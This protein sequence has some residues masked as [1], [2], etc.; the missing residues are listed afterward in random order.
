[1]GKSLS[2][3]VPSPKIKNPSKR[4]KY[5]IHE[6]FTVILGAEIGAGR[7][8][9]LHHARLEISTG[10]NSTSSHDIIAK[11]AFDDYQRERIYHEYD[12]YYHLA[13]SGVQGYI[14]DVYGLFEDLEGGALALLMSYE[15]KTLREHSPS[16]TSVEE[17]N[18]SS[19][20]R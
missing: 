14:P 20:I 16:D 6:C 2:P 3:L 19:G 9:I 15:G 4:S 8:G 7:T 10:G 18:V 13:S 12:I 17:V 1:M 5:Y 11:L